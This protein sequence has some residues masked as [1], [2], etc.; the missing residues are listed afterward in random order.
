MEKII[1]STCLSHYDYALALI[2]SRWEN[3]CFI[4]FGHLLPKS[5]QW[6]LKSGHSTVSVL[7]RTV[8]S[9]AIGHG[10]WKPSLP[11]NAKSNLKYK[12]WKI[13]H[14]EYSN[15]ISQLKK[16]NHKNVSEKVAAHTLDLTALVAITSQEILQMKNLWIDF[17]TKHL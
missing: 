11:L 3:H 4:I 13:S 8:L 16:T 9:S 5:K 1:N 6:I 2:T 17:E 15:F 14:T 10:V 7:K 12:V